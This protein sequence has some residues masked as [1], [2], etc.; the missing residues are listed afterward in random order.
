MIMKIRLGR[1]EKSELPREPHL[2]IAVGMLP[3][4]LLAPSFNGLC[5]KIDQDCS[6]SYIFHVILG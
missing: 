3:V 1:L 5:C 6:I 2:F 4:E